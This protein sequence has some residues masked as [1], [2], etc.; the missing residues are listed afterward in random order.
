MAVA[1]GSPEPAPDRP[2]GHILAIGGGARPEKLMK[3]FVELA[4]LT[5]KPKVVIFTMAS[6]A[7]DETGPG[8][9]SDLKAAG[10][11]EAEYYHF[12]REDALRPETADVLDGAG[13]V[14]FSGGD[15]S[16]LTGVVLGTP[17]HD[18]LLKLYR[19]GGIIGGTSAGAAVM[20]G[21]MITG[22]EKRRAEPGDE[23]ATIEAENIVTSKGFGFIDNAII[24]QHFLKRKRL[25]R[26]FSLVLENP[27]LIGLGIDEATAALFRPDGKI[28]VLGDGQVLV[29]DARGAGIFLSP[30]NKLGA[31]G[32]RMSIL[33]DEAVYCPET[34]QVE[35][36][37]P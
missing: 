2:K 21:I 18:R 34:G 36:R 9:V 1:C 16:R 4:R 25:N 12:K 33:L 15:Q 32:L 7:P 35:G 8:L 13:G 5:G 24:D 23:W 30:D 28:E 19:E 3:R 22:D 17:L 31:T 6:G 37:L 20:S 29:I 27:G 11:S 10:A 26:L 14:F